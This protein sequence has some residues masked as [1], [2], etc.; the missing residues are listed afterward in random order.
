MPAPPEPMKAIA[1]LKVI[2]GKDEHDLIGEAI[3]NF[4]RAIRDRRAS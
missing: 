2:N 1:D 4:E 3:E